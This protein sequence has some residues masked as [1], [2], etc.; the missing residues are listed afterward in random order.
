[1]KQQTLD[2]MVRERVLLVASAKDHLVIGNERLQALFRNDPQ[3]AM[4]RRPDGSVNA[5]LLAAQGMSSAAFAERLRQDY[6]MRQ[7]LGGVT[8]SEPAGGAAEQLAVDAL[9]QRREVQL[10]SFEPKDYVDKINPSEADV[11][12]YYQ[13]HTAQFRAPERA[14]INYV[15]LDAEALKSQIT[16]SDEELAK[17]YKENLSRYTQAEERQASHILINAG[18]DEP[19]ATREKAKARAEALLAEVRKNPDSFAELAKKNSQDVG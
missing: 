13:A 7:V 4:V 10:Q 18:K 5:E 16:V 8:G 11:Q 17:Y 3:Y 14:T 6:A 15:V 9:L 1:M 2:E 19:A 12:A